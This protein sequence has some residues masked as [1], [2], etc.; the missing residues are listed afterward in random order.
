MDPQNQNDFSN[1][2]AQSDIEIPSQPQRNNWFNYFKPTVVFILV[3]LVLFGVFRLGYNIGQSGLSF[4]VREFKLVNKNN[5]NQE[6]DYSLL[7]QALDVVGRKYIDKDQIDQKKVLY[8]AISGAVKA[9]GDEYTEFFDPETLA[10]FKTELKGTFSGIGAEIGKQ[11]GNIVIIAPLDDSPAQKAGL[12]AKDVIVKINDQTVNDWST[13]EAAHAI[14]GDAGTSVKL[15]VFREG[16]DAP[17]DLNIVRAQIEVKSVKVTYKEVNGKQIAVL[18]VT[19]FGDDTKKLFDISVADI[20]NKNVAGIVVDL[21]NN[22]G[23]YLDTAVQ[24]ASDWLTPDKLVVKEAHSEKDVISY[25]SDGTNRLGN[26]KTVVLINGGSASAAEIL[27]GTLKDN[28]KAILIGEK[29]FGK[30]S[31]Q[32]LVSLSS[33]TA[34][35]VTIAKWITPSGKNLNKDG[36]NPDIE[37]KLTDDDIKNQRDPQLDRALQEA[38][39]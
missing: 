1:L 15:T 37:V 11:N 25:N 35:K 13:D 20:K 38:S 18:S 23:G 19:K 10:A 7:W 4:S 8:G 9:A 22:P 28:G 32:E 30:G 5:P 14:R 29:S 34:V 3:L 6:V 39:K 27:S 17:F 36:L 2:G 12:R 33:D 26:I 21:R 24:L 31:V 16:S